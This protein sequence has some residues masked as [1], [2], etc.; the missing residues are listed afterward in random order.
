M[1]ER[2]PMTVSPPE[3][4][5]PGVD[6]D[7][8]LDGG[9]AFLPGT[10]CRLPWA[11]TARPASRPGRCLTHVADLRGLADHHA[12]PVVDDERL[13][14]RRAGW[15][16]MPVYAV[17]VLASSCGAAWARPAP[18]IRG[19]LASSVSASTLNP[20]QYILKGTPAPFSGF[21]VEKDRIE[22][23][24]EVANELKY[25]KKLYETE[26]KYR[27]MKEENAVLKAKLEFAA[28]ASE[29]AAII[30]ALKKELAKEKVF[31]KQYWFTIPATILIYNFT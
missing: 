12:G 14:D 5:A 1:I 25:Y 22:K 26:M 21:L 2:A 9:V 10:A 28:K 16:S 11:E 18:I 13:A 7:V 20:S 6:D 17:H 31:Y 27:D 23:S 3:D 24:V 8:V 19:F 4:R 30:D 29:D 15:M